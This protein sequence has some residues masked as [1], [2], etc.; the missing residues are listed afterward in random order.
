MR[1]RAVGI[2][3]QVFFACV[4]RR[5]LLTHVLQFTMIWGS[6]L[7]G[8]W[9]GLGPGKSCQSVQLY[10]FSGFGPF[11]SGVCFRIRFWKGS[12]MHL[13]RFGCRLGHPLGACGPLFQRLGATLVACRFHMFFGGFPGP[14]KIS[15]RAKVGGNYVESGALNSRTTDQQTTAEQQTSRH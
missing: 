1:L 5:C 11:W 13:G 15:S 7:G 14:V 12:G 3:F 8:F 10:A 6:V 9:G 2:I 4:F